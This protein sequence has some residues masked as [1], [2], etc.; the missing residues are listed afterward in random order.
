[1][2]RGSSRSKNRQEC[3]IWC[4]YMLYMHV[5]VCI[6]ILHTYSGMISKK[7]YAVPFEGLWSA[8][9]PAKRLKDPKFGAAG[10]VLSSILKICFKVAPP[11]FSGTYIGWFQVPRML[12]RNPRRMKVVAIRNGLLWNGGD[13][14]VSAGRKVQKSSHSEALRKT[15][16]QPLKMVEMQSSRE[17]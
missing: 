2:I 16:R 4:M 11:R 3:V 17:K 13:A 8:S 14:R 9:L 5:N 12:P 7:Y 15:G 10:A 1:M 6:H